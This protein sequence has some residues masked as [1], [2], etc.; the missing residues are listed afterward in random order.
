[1]RAER[2]ADPPKSLVTRHVFA[3]TPASGVALVGDHIVGAGGQPFREAHRNAYGEEYFGATGP[4]QNIGSPEPLPAGKHVVQYEFVPEST[5]PGAGGLATLSVNG[6]GS[7]GPFRIER[8]LGRGGMREVHLALDTRLDRLVAIKSLPAHLA[9]DPERL[10]RFQREAK[11]LASL[12]HP[13][14]AAIYGLEEANGHRYLVLEYVEGGTLAERI[15]AGP[16]PVGEALSI[17]DRTSSRSDASS[18]RCSPAS[19]PSA[20]RPWPIRSPRFSIASLTSRSSPRICRGGR[21]SFSRAA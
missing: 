12:S 19:L 3:G 6:T 1:M 21:A 5:K 18:T 15:A 20:A 9:Q 11:L 4:V 13:G 16:I 7:V 14:I 8:E 2:V 17:A 10:A